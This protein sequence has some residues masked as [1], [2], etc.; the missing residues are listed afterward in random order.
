MW[1]M[2]AHNVI[3]GMHN[4][5]HNIIWGV[6]DNASSASQLMLLCVHVCVCV[7]EEWGEIIQEHA[8]TK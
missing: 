8:Q 3:I 5:L 1:Y 4:Q 2:Q 7:D 6:L